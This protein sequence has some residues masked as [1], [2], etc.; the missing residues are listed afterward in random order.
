MLR[1]GID[2]PARLDPAVLMPRHVSQVF[3]A[4]LIVDQVDDECPHDRTPLFDRGPLLAGLYFGTISRFRGNGFVSCAKWFQFGR[5]RFAPQRRKPRLGGRRGLLNEAWIGGI[6]GFG[7]QTP[8]TG[9]GSN[10]NA[11]QAEYVRLAA[12][13]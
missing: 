8:E 6:I 12:L 9:K 10:N 1:C 3:A 13:R 4:G 7:D 5:Q 2:E 11:A